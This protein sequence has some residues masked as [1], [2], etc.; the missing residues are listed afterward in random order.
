MLASSGRVATSIFTSIA[1]TS[2]AMPGSLP[3][4]VSGV[5]DVPRHQL[6]TMCR[7]KTRPIC[8]VP[9]TENAPGSRQPADPAPRLRATVVGATVVG[10]AAQRLH[11]DAR[12]HDER[13]HGDDGA[14]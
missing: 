13:A 1:V 12:R 11:P 14:R 5:S 2:L 7:E 6:S 10:A 9:T 4:R 8:P 3:G